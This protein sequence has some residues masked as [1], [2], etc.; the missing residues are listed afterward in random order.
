MELPRGEPPEHDFDNIE[1]QVID[2]YIPDSDRILQDRKR[3]DAALADGP[4]APPDEY[5]IYM[6]GATAD[7]VSVCT[8]VTEF[9]P[10]FF[11]KPPPNWTDAKK[12]TEDLKKDLMYKSVEKKWY[13]RST[14]K[15]ETYMG[16]VVP[17]KF[18][19][20]FKYMKVVYRKDFFGFTNETLFPYIKIRV[21]SIAL[22][23]VLK[24]YF[25]E[26]AQIKA[27]FKICESNLEP[28]LRFIHEKDIQ[29][30]GWVKIPAGKY[31]EIEPDEETGESFSRAAWNIEVKFSDIR[32]LTYNKIAPLLIASFDIECTS[33]HGDFPVAKK[34]YKKLAS[35]VINAAR[36]VH[37]LDTTLLCE[38]IKNAY[39]GNVS[40][41]KDVIINKLYPKTKV[42]SKALDKLLN[43]DFLTELLQEVQDAARDKGSLCEGSDDENEDTDDTPVVKKRG[44]SVHEQQVVKM[45]T[46][47]LPALQGD[48]II[49]IGT[50]VNRYG[51]DNIIYK[52][53]VTLGDCTD[54][55][56]AEVETYSTE[57]EVILAWKEF[58]SRL[59]PDILAGYNIFGFDMRYMWERAQ[60]TGVV[61]EFAMGLGRIRGRKT[62]LE[63]KSLSS[64]A[65]GDNIMY[66][67]DTDG[68]VC[69]DQF[70]VTQR[71]EKLESYKLDFVAH[72]FL[73]DNKNDLK[74]RE[75]F[76]KFG[77]T[78]DD[79]AEIARYC[80]QDCALVNR[81]MHNRK[82]LENNVG[83]GNV[84]F[85]PLKYLFM[86]G[87]GIKIFSLV[88]KE[89][90]EKQYIIPVLQRLGDTEDIDEVGYEGAIVLQ[91]KTGMYLD[92]P[93]SVLD[94]SSLYPSSMISRNISHDCYI[95]DKK[96]LGLEDKGVSYLNIEY[97]IFE[98]KGDKKKAVGKQSCTFA[99]LPDN[100]KG[101]MPSILMMLLDARKST[102]KKIEFKTA[103]L[104]DGTK[105]TGLQSTKDN[106]LVFT[107]PETKMSVP[108]DKADIATIE[109]T[110]TDAEKAILDARQLAYKITA[111]SLYGQC[112]SR[113]SPIYLK[114]IAAA[115]TATG[116]EMICL[117]RDFVTEKYNA[118]VI[119]G[120][121]V[122]GYTPIT[123]LQGD[124]ITVKT[125]ESMANAW[126]P[127]PQFKA[128][129]PGR[130]EKQQAA[131]QNVY[132]WTQ[133]GWA[134]VVRVI[135]HKTVK[136]IF[137][138]NTARGVVDVT[139]DHSL[140]TS[141]N[142]IVK[143][144]DLC[145]GTPLLHNKIQSTAQLN[146]SVQLGDDLGNEGYVYSNDQVAAQEYVL[147]LQRRGF[148]VSLECETTMLHTRYRIQYN[149]GLS[150]AG[151][152]K[153]VALL[154]PAYNGYVYDIETEYGV[155]HAGIGDLIV[156]NTDSIFCK[157]PIHDEETGAVVKGKA[158]L[159]G[160][161]KAGQRAAE[162]IKAVLPQYQSLAYEKTLFPFILFSKKRYVGNLYEDDHTVK[163]KQKSMGIALKRRD[164]APLVKKIYGGIINILL[165]ENDLDASVQFFRSQLR[166]LVDGKYP[167]EDLIISKTLKGEYKDPSKI[168]HRV[169]ADRIGERD[170]G[171][172]PMVND[173]IPF[174]YIHAPEA[175]LQGDRIEHPEYI[176]DNGIT[177]DYQF[178]I[179]NQL[180]KPIT[181]LYALCVENMP[182]YCYPPGYWL[183]MDIEMMEHK[184]YCDPIKRKDRIQA[185]MQREVED[186]LFK[187]F[188]TPKVKAVRAKAQP[189]AKTTPDLQEQAT[190][191]TR[192]KRVA[193]KRAQPQDESV[194]SD[195]SVRVSVKIEKK[196]I[197]CT[198][199]DKT[200]PPKKLQGET[201]AALASAI[202]GCLMYVA[203]EL[204]FTGQVT[205]DVSSA[206]FRYLY[207]KACD[208]YAN[209]IDW[210]VE[211][212][213]CS[214]KQDVSKLSELQAIQL[215]S[216]LMEM[217]SK[218]DIVLV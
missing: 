77:G 176:R 19:S 69:I 58:I 82:V 163:P 139:E 161:I 110:F 159:P 215:M 30:C 84:C 106:T 65:L 14:K 78:A 171:N 216:G 147:I 211:L 102:R 116:R 105:V 184:L 131:L 145:I 144:G 26:P 191:T 121:S 8:K 67:I 113:T 1:F 38:W 173:R 104:T 115:T 129:E 210:N 189:K 76:E 167:L 213:K 194:T 156:K 12:S 157:F 152:V 120:D 48:P 128:G 60:E 119:Y 175:K 218:F 203:T 150:C 165:N 90:R 52:H 21:S 88:A 114:E 41:R 109:D 37:T 70:K 18:Q 197:L 103:T 43:D 195:T 96:Y 136:R 174:V 55:P 7:G 201:V 59:D 209:D 185:L 141:D 202:Q 190:P 45:L 75:I 99:Q 27:G 54:I 217:R 51:S 155:F 92:D 94:Y 23:N 166:D 9:Q 64:S 81:L 172:K 198:V 66:I 87:Q 214:A 182:G 186:V 107:N 15:Y 164:Y 32:A 108:V 158:A 63:T 6:F 95:M 208:M 127:Y 125:I 205:L 142:D 72:H 20:H 123:T 31:T 160:A 117:A 206:E 79:R 135:R 17:K 133:C 112:G 177:P 4:A 130:T 22:Y 148:T 101:I 83:M 118:D 49:Q 200:L 39:V 124:T 61:D 16:T 151:N 93:I 89:C 204:K 178:Y 25:S 62:A 187:E 212:R 42:S 46:S 199:Q 137:R 168:A 154:T 29:P 57:G 134:R 74:P 162:E 36:Y 169:L 140:L 53:I 207:P 71:D 179:T 80:L 86:R 2:W 40:V 44:G 73:K 180:M 111:N 5:T 100:K 193:R 138:V 153:C 13:N 56:G 97:D 122:M 143:P 34:D 10:Y 132:V 3:A 50:T 183:Q 85:V 188:L 126:M 196:T 28:F 47:H 146:L 192:T 24:R 33:S 181:Q 98:G 35:D 68:I 149:N 91:P 11:V 170:E